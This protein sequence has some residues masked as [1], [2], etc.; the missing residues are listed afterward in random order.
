MRRW[1]EH[2]R[3][4]RY[5][6]KVLTGVR[7]NVGLNEHQINSAITVWEVIGGNT[8]CELDVRDASEHGTFTR[9]NER[10]R[11]VLLG[12][13]AFPWNASDPR[14]HMSV[15]ACLAHE[16][17]HAQRHRLEFDRPV[18]LPDKQV[19]EAETSLHASFNSVLYRGDRCDLVRDA[20]S[21]LEAWIGEC[22]V[23][24]NL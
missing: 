4:R 19:D 18:E 22:C 6:N 23:E 24:G 13:D 14:S 8:V 7:N 15:T 11:C 3:R 5:R 2:R 21:C 17:A 9:Y 12:A 20:V 16:L 1:F 10:R